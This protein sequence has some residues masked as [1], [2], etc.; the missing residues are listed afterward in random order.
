VELDAEAAPDAESGEENKE[1][2]E[3][4]PVEITFAEYKKQL[5][6]RSKPEF[7][8]RKANEG[9]KL[10]NLK[11][12][13]TKQTEDDQEEEGSIYFP[14]TYIH[15]SVKTSGRDKKTV[16]CHFQYSKG[17]NR[18]MDSDRGRGGRGRGRGGRGRGRGGG[19]DGDRN[20]SPVESKSTGGFGNAPAP[21][22]ASEDFPELGGN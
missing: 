22:L 4:E 18:H 11:E 14:P 9:E 10:K 20:D 2:V 6:E 1:N 12:L 15:E 19:R 13:K 3:E 8:L 21:A 16:E 7:N 17:E 5:E